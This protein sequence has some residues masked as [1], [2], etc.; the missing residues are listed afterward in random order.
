[1]AKNY[2]C[3][4]CNYRFVPKTDAEPRRCPYCS[5]QGTL[6]TESTATQILRDV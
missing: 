6:R 3:M 1:M 2:R 4:K 5:T